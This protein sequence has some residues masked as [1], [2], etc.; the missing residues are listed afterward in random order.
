MQVL[1][2]RS[3]IGRARQ[4][5]LLENISEACGTLQSKEL[6]NAKNEEEVLFHND[7]I[8]HLNDHWITTWPS[9]NLGFDTNFGMASKSF[10]TFSYPVI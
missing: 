6:Y 10:P 1:L 5:K 4:K 3:T 2:A 7:S 8:T 9:K